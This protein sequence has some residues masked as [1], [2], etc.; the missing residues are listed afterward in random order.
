MINSKETESSSVGN[1]AIALGPIAALLVAGLLARFRDSV[2]ATNVALILAMVVVA[3]ALAGRTA[4]FVTAITAAV[5]FNYFHTKPFHS[6]RIDGARDVTT[7]VLLALIGFVVSEIGAWRRRM[8]SSAV[9]RLHGVRALETVAAMIAG[10]RPSGEIWET[11]HQIL[12]DE[13]HLSDCRFEAAG[14]GSM[15]VLPRSGAL[16]GPTMHLLPHGFTLP[17]GGIQIEVEAR[18]ESFGSIVLVPDARFG[19]SHD[20]RAV[21]I[22]LADQFALALQLDSNDV[23]AR[24]QQL[25]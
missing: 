3:A 22:A 5:V 7:V 20:A 1:L 21:A 17:V 9:K 6:L 12:I 11:I 14:A 10:D 15:P 13:L 16:V 4:G 2:G 8:H 24:R 18:G 23:H 25:A 19:S